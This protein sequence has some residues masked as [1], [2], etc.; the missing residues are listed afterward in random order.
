[1]NDTL[2]PLFDLARLKC[3][4]MRV[5]IDF[6]RRGLAAVH[7]E[8]VYRGAI[9][10]AL[11]RDAP[12]TLADLFDTRATRLSGAPTNLTV[13]GIV[14]LADEADSGGEQRRHWLTIKL[15]GA[16]HM[17]GPRIL[18]ALVTGLENGIGERRVPARI[19]ELHALNINGRWQASRMPLLGETG[20]FA[21]FSIPVDGRDTA[22]PAGPLPATLRLDVRKRMRL[23]EAKTPM[24]AVPEFEFLLDR[25]VERVRQVAARWGDGEVVSP[26]GCDVLMATARRVRIAQGAVSRTVPRRLKS[27]R[28]Q[29]SYPS[30]GL[31]GSLAYCAEYPSDW[32]MLLPW[33]LAGRL[34]H[35]GQQTTIGLGTYEIR[36]ES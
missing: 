34:L 14:L 35:V 25:I 19:G 26:Q 5:G 33:L 4:V 13:P 8:E 23:L 15:L 21:G 2:Q 29:A 17:H 6:E 31:T 3:V 36:F 22:P 16:A 32:G 18:W 11:E 9:K 30:V 27:S 24:V 1:M 20:L 10:H 28:Q 12:D 7:A